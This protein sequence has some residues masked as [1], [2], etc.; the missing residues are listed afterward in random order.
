[1]DVK[2]TV[3]DSAIVK[4]INLDVQSY[5][6]GLGIATIELV[7]NFYCFLFQTMAEVEYFL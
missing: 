4:S 5:V 6:D 7:N 2:R 1:M 3:Q